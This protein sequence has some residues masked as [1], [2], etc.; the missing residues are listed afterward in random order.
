MKIC[1]T[2]LCVLLVALSSNAQESL[3]PAKPEIPPEF[4]RPVF[5]QAVDNE[6]KI[7]DFGISYDF[8]KS[9]GREVRIGSFVFNDSSFSAKIENDALNFKWNASLISA[10]GITAIN[11]F[12]EEIWKSKAEGNGEWSFKGLDGEKGPHWK[13]RERFRFC[14]RHQT[15]LEYVNICSSWYGLEREGTVQ[16]L[17]P[18]PSEATAQIIIKNE[19]QKMTG[20][21]NVE[22][23]TPVQFFARLKSDATYEFVAVPENLKVRDLIV[24]EKTSAL[25]LTGAGQRPLMENVQDVPQIQ[26]SKLTRALGFERS[27]AEPEALWQVEL[28]EWERDVQIDLPGKRGGVFTCVLEIKDPPQQQDRIF[29]RENALFDTYLGK[30]QVE[31]ANSKGEVKTWEYTTGAKFSD[32]TA[33]IDAG[34]EKTNHKAY[35]NV[36]RGASGEAG[37][38]LVQAVTTEN[39]YA[40]LGE[41][42]FAWW[43]NDV[44]GSQNYWLSK[45]RWGVTAR[46]LGS[47]TDIPTN[48][49]DRVRLDSFEAE[50]RYRLS[51][52]LWWRDEAVGIYAGYDSLKIGELSTPMMGA[53]IFWTRSMP[54]AIDDWMNKASFFNH[55]KWVNAEFVNYFSSLDSGYTLT[56]NYGFNMTAKMMSSPGFFWDVTLGIRRNGFERKSDDASVSLTTINGSLGVGI[57]F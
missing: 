2:T 20:F 51:P 13:D 4:N 19:P 46:Y 32:T 44:F 41:A 6:L 23:G 25:V 49:G 55:P 3:S 37:V 57:D 47:F 50:L 1:K 16:K 22:V 9:K 11:K 34:G 7:K 45:Q 54:R 31:Y 24:A 27:I 21:Y 48:R 40:L 28:K 35:L 36:H 17:V 5:F 42:N 15:D 26:Y 8:G 18:A 43:F 12:G 14:M 10:G 38:K 39:G 33:T 52:G 30:D 56:Q 53:G 29:L